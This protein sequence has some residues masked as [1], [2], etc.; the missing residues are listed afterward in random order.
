[1]VDGPRE[2]VLACIESYHTVVL[3]VPVRRRD[4]GQV[5]AELALVLGMIAFG[6]I[7]ALVY[8]GGG[9][10]RLFDSSADPLRPGGVFLPPTAPALTYPTALVD[11]EDDGWKNFP[12]FADQA[13]CEAYVEGVI[14]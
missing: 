3:D 12:Q 1:M 11:C 5:S 4:S 7:V 2:A 10:T 14:P 13:A 6:C 8:L 9:V